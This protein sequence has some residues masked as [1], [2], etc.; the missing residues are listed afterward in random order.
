MSSKS[1]KGTPCSRSLHRYEFLL[2]FYCKADHTHTHVKGRVR[3]QRSLLPC[4]LTCWKTE[5]NL[6]RFL[7]KY[8]TSFWSTKE[9]EDYWPMLQCLSGVQHAAGGNSQDAGSSYLCPFK[10]SLEPARHKYFAYVLAWTQNGQGRGWRPWLYL[11]FLTKFLI[12]FW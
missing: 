1:L 8:V 9:A 2:K 11:T 3:P 7:Q 5:L 6:A 12:K 4:P 10:N